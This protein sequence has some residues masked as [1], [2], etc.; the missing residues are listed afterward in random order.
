MAVVCHSYLK[1]RGQDLL[2]DRLTRAQDFS[3]GDD[4]PVQQMINEC[5]HQKG[6]HKN[7]FDFDLL[8]WALQRAG[9]SACEHV[10]EQR[11][12]QRFESFPPRHDDYMTLYVKATR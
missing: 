12:K 6:Q 7:L 2:D 8:A 3:L 4:V 11:F 9:F 1:H 5:F 10:D